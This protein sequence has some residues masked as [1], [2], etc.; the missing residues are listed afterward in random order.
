MKY[1]LLAFLCFSLLFL[2]C[3]VEQIKPNEIEDIVKIDNNYTEPACDLD[4]NEI[5]YNTYKCTLNMVIDST[6]SSIQKECVNAT[7]KST[8]MIKGTYYNFDMNV[9]FIGIPKTGNYSI[10]E[11]NSLDKT[12]SL[13]CYLTT[14]SGSFKAVKGT[15]LHVK[16]DGKS[17]TVGFC[18][19]E[20]ITTS[21]YNYASKTAK[22][23]FTCKY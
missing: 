4:S 7:L 18:E 21:N 17:I 6:S 22:G 10:T 20:L 11:S 2:S 8:G 14:D 9:Y 3:E 13:S 16:N 15:V 23:M 19:T 1:S 12:N 5:I